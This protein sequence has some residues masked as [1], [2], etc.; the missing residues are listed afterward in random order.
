MGLRFKGEY[1]SSVEWDTTPHTVV[2]ELR[3]ADI[4]K[5]KPVVAFLKQYKLSYTTE[6][7]AALWEFF[8][9]DGSEFEEDTHVNACH[10]RIHS[11]GALQFILDYKHTND[12]GWL[13]CNVEDGTPF[14]ETSETDFNEPEI[15]SDTTD[16]L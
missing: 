15:V 8:N 7:H 13:N 14:E 5:I 10:L 6:Y 16:K 12:E 11:D 1:N 9:E 2:C 3:N 4:E